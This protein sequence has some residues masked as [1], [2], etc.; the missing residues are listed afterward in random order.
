MRSSAPGAD[1]ICNK[2]HVVARTGASDAVFVCK[3]PDGHV[4][5]CS[6]AKHAAQGK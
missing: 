6:W 3:L 1:G 2:T 5:P 4:G